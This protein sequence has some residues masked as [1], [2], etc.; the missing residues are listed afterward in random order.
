M[1]GEL[2]GLSSAE[3]P[4]IPGIPGTWFRAD[5]AQVHLVGAPP[6]GS[7]IDPTG[8]HFCFGVEDI[9]AAVAELEERRI[10]YR[11]GSQGPVVQIWVADPAGNTIE[12]QQDRPL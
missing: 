12:L 4:E 2:L 7:E 10:P 3:R 5:D 8:P 9:E 1:Y 6:E 11:R